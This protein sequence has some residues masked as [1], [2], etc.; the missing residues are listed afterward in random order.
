MFNSPPV[1]AYTDLQALAKLR[2]LAKDNS[3][4][5][6]RAVAAQFEAQFVHLMLKSMRDASL[7][8][9]LFESDQTRLYQ[10]IFDQQLALHLSQHKGI[11]LADIIVKQWG[12]NTNLAGQPAANHTLGNG[13]AT[14]GQAN[15]SASHL[16]TT[17][18]AR[19][20]GDG[21]AA[22]QSPSRGVKQGAENDREEPTPL[23]FI[24]KLWPPAQEAARSLGVHPRVLL[25]Q[26]ALETGWGRRIPGHPDGRSSHNLFGIK[27]D[28]SWQGDRLTLPTLEYVQDLAMR[29]QAVFR[30]YRSFAESFA[31][32]V[33][34]LRS[35]PRYA[36]ALRLVD[37]PEDFIRALQQAGYATDPAYAHKIIAILKGE[38][39]TQALLDLPRHDG[40]D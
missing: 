19:A 14:L 33:N 36:Q 11:G 26:A 27:V 9:G 3:P 22:L 40:S 38:T 30:S 7:G 25:A 24:H 2:T 21:P 1:T 6:L 13:Q 28:A 39:L 29:G 32:Y 4:Q 34:F 35:N 31:D 16:A 10:D 18:M 20:Q 5:A 8:E 23:E 37:D 12:G 15:V 17:P